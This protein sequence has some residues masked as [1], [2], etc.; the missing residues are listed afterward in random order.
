MPYILPQDVIA[1]K[2]Y[3]ALHR[4]LIEGEAGKPLEFGTF[5]QATDTRARRAGTQENPNRR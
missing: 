2:E 4:V 5:S 3:W 1:P